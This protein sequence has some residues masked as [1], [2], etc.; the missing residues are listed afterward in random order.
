MILGP[1]GATEEELLEAACGSRCGANSLARAPGLETENLRSQIKNCR[2]C[3]AISSITL[4]P[5]EFLMN[6]LKS[7]YP[8]LNGIEVIVIGR[9]SCW[10]AQNYVYR[11]PQGKD[12]FISGVLNL[13]GAKSVAEFKKNCVLT[14]ALRCHALVAPVPEK[15]LENCARHL[16]EELRLFSNARTIVLLGE[17]AY[18]QFYRFVLGRESRD[19]PSWDVLLGKQGWAV[20]NLSL[21][22]P[23]GR[24]LRVISCYHPASYRSS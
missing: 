11:N 16:R 2:D 23:E 3:A 6:Y 15:A 12:R 22:A 14:D 5:R 18:L 20:E 13:V 10:N 21:P 17:D 19:V 7:D 4:P 1:R 8:D 24:A 9:D